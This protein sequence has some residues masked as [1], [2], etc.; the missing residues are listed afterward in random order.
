MKIKKTLIIIFLS[1]IFLMGCGN[2]D[3]GGGGGAAVDLTQEDTEIRFAYHKNVE[4][5]I[6][7]I[8]IELDALPREKDEEG[9]FKGFNEPQIPLLFSFPLRN[10][11]PYTAGINSVFDHSIARDPKT[12]LDKDPR[13]PNQ[14]VMNYRGEE[15]GRSQDVLNISFRQS[16]ESNNLEDFDCDGDG[17]PEPNA[18]YAY[19]NGDNI[20]FQVNGHYNGGKYLSYDS[21]FGVDFETTDQTRDGTLCKDIPSDSIKVQ[22]CSSKGRSNGKTEVIAAAPGIALYPTDKSIFVI[23]HGRPGVDQTIRTFYVHLD[24]RVEG[25]KQVQRGALIGI[26]GCQGSCTGPHLHFAVRKRINGL[27]IPVDP[28]GWEPINPE[29]KDPFASDARLAYRL[30]QDVVNV[31]LWDQTPPS[32]SPDKKPPTIEAFSVSSSSIVRGDS[33]QI[34]FTGLDTGGSGLS[35]AELWRFDRCTTQWY[36]AYK[37]V[38]LS[39]EGPATNSFTDIPTCANVWYGLHIKD[40]ANNENDENNSATGGSPGK[41]GP[42]LVVVTDPPNGTTSAD[43]INPTVNDFK[44]S[45]T[46]INISENIIVS[47]VVEDKGGSGLKEAELWRFDNCTNKWTVGLKTVVLNGNGPISGSFIDAPTCPNVWYGLHVSDNSGNTNDEQNSTTNGQPADFGPILV[48]VSQSAIPVTND[49]IIPIV[50]DFRVSATSISLG[51][52]VTVSYRVSDDGGSGLKVAELW[53][54]KE[55]AKVWE[56]AIM[57]I[58]LSGSGPIGG[59]F[60]DSPDCSAWYGFHVKDNANNENDEQN[61]ATGGLPGDF[62]PIYVQVQP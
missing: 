35:K 16:I 52:S 8:N 46:S 3:K 58:P 33:V 21:H 31:R 25:L 43:N 45:A 2:T 62:G 22:E 1:S 54:F 41:F 44:T 51:G 57:T 5:T 11:E 17:R 30:S 13:C 40:R 32:S 49:R 14:H 50:E 38:D 15:T 42:I 61:S 60:T 37:T 9:S 10:K 36:P 24:S 59:A 28:Y 53:R 26:S 20:A 48:N 55:C 12:D 4:S 34:S 23:E 47:F 27:W 39:G 6:D 56:P 7:R 18:L 19:R 29:Q